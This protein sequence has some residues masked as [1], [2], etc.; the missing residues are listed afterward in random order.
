MQS[1]VKVHVPLDSELSILS[2][3]ILNR[4]LLGEL[5]EDLSPSDFVQSKYSIIFREMLNAVDLGLVPLDGKAKPFPMDILAFHLEKKGLLDRVGGKDFI[6]ELSESAFTTGSLPYHVSQVKIAALKREVRNLAGVQDDSEFFECFKELAAKANLVCL[7]ESHELEKVILTAD[8]SAN[9]DLAPKQKFLDPWLTQNSITLISGRRGI[10]K[11]FFAMGLAGAV[12]NSK[13]FG[14]WKNEA[15]ARVLFIDGEMDPRDILERI[16]KLGLVCKELFIY[17]DALAWQR[18]L[19]RANLTNHEWR[20]KIKSFML[21]RQIRL[22]VFDN[23]A[24]L[25]P[26][27]DENR[28]QD[29]DPINQWLLELRFHGIGSILLHHV[30]KQ[31]EQRGTSAREDNLDNSIVLK[32]PTGHAS[33]QGCKFIVQFKKARVRN[34]ELPMISDTEFSLNEAE[35]GHYIW[36]S[37][38]VKPKRRDQILK[39]LDGGL[40]QKDVAETLGVDKSYVSRIRKKAIADGY[41]DGSNKLT[42]KGVMALNV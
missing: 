5:R 18:G 19:P 36:T 9:I 23:I 30:G 11:T 17:S 29:W 31:G 39:L 7:G 4:S 42:Q 16:K 14:P 40:S 15:S 8:Q 25:A 38:N 6:F 1:N 22:C 27:L 26:N 33:H 34:A 37:A 20:E 24:S 41:L 10:G 21:T 3:I 28:K 2:A 35:D 32:S 12:A 13:P